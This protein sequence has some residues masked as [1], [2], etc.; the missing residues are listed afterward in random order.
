MTHGDVPLDWP[1]SLSQY[2]IPE[3]EILRVDTQDEER[4]GRDSLGNAGH[5]R[6]VCVTGVFGTRWPR[7]R[8]VR[9]FETL[10]FEVTRDARGENE[11][12]YE[13][14]ET[15]LLETDPLLLEDRVLLSLRGRD[16]AGQ[17]RSLLEAKAEALRKELEEGSL[18]PDRRDA[19]VTMLRAMDEGL[20]TT[21][22]IRSV[23][24]TFRT[25]VA[26]RRPVESLGEEIA[27]VQGSRLVYRV[28]AKNEAMNDDE[29]EPM[30][31]HVLSLAQNEAVIMFLG[32][33][34]GL[35]HVTDLEGSYVHNAWFSNRERAKTTATAPWLGRGLYRRLL[36]EG[37]GEIVIHERRDT[38]PTRIEKVGEEISSVCVDG[39]PRDVPVLRCK[40]ERGDELL[41]LADEANPL[42]LRLEEAGVEL[43]RTID[44]VRSPLETRDPRVEE[45]P[46]SRPISRPADARVESVTQ[47]LEG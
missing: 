5:I 2:W 6:K 47:T 13:R 43:I 42:V 45:R 24:R 21:V 39:E 20:R 26:V 30:V 17:Q 3:A 25:A 11:M 40:T 31:F 16:F 18:E 38:E 19:V 33:L 12:R 7:S 46:I 22:E 44:D 8:I 9:Q 15:E 36:R 10:G 28:A 32:G 4:P 34:H 27:L 23:V 41:V 1:E 37:H 29:A 14:R 35:R